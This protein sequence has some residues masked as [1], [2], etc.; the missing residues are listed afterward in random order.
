MKESEGIKQKLYIYIY[1]YSIGKDNSMVIARGVEVGGD[2]QRGINGGRKR[3]F[4]G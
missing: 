4:F 3:L 2:G 1:I